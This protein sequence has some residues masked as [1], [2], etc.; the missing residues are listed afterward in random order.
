M[1]TITLTK[2]FEEIHQ[3]ALAAAKFEANKYFNEQLNGV[4]QYACGFAWVKVIGVRLNTKLGKAMK[5]M[6]FSKS[7]NTGIELWNPSGMCVQ[8]I[9]VKEVGAT[10]Y[11]KV[12]QNY[13]I[14][15]YAQSRLD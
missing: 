8:N 14:D 7:W 2:S 4:D 6:G 10:A 11:A 1:A 3:E 15:A 13:G 5:E 12:L 9:D